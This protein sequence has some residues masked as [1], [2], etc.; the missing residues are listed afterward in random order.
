MIYTFSS[1][2]R[3]HIG[4]ILISTFVLGLSLLT[5]LF[6][7]SNREASTYYRERLDLFENLPNKDHTIV[8]VGDSIIENAEWHEFFPNTKVA[9]RGIK[10]D[11]VKGVSE[12]LNNIIETNASKVFLMVGINDLLRN[13]SVETI[14]SIYQHVIKEL[15]SNHESL[16]IQ[17]TLHVRNKSFLVNE[18]VIFLNESL[19]KLSQKYENTF[20]IDLNERLSANN[21]LKSEFTSDGKH[22]NGDGYQEWISIIATF[23]HE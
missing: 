2:I 17:S 3:R 22:L 12:R 4:L 21:Q 15:A 9:N 7:T 18:N 19:R 6:L 14:L 10:G 16:F 20:F 13:H 1:N 23:V 11:T 5:T 8:F